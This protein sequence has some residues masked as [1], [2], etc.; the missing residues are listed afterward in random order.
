MQGGPGIFKGD[1]YFFKVEGDMSDRI[2]AIDT[3]T[4]PVYML[5][6]EYDYACS[7]EDSKAAADAIP[8]AELVIMD[9]LGH[10]PMSEN[11]ETFRTHLL[12]VL[13]K[14]L[15]ADNR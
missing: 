12:P 11:P 15:E 13:E 9:E 4:C 5:T 14:I 3:N 8:G 1:L 6:G 7:P 2:G 10:F